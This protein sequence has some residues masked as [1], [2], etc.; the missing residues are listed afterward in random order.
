MS[1]KGG[2]KVSPK[3]IPTRSSA[4]LRYRP[5]SD[6]SGTS[7]LDM[8]LEIRTMIYGYVLATDAD[9]IRPLDRQEAGE[10]RLV[11]QLRSQGRLAR[12]LPMLGHGRN[13]KLML[14]ERGLLSVNK[15][16]HAEATQVLVGSSPVFI[17]NDAMETKNAAMANRV[18]FV[19]HHAKVLAINITSVDM[20]TL[21]MNM[22]VEKTNLKHLR[23]E[24]D[25]DVS[26]IMF[27]W[28]ASKEKTK[29]ELQG[30]GQI[31]VLESMEM[32]YDSGGTFS[33]EF[34][35]EEENIQRFLERKVVPL[36][37]SD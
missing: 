30:L 9:W 23:V 25:D 35:G 16:V 2:K 22:L 21:Y 14:Y 32:V 5:K 13:V 8:S 19:F 7:L 34:D 17:P 3:A 15:Q 36:M 10:M 31:K 1:K 28:I 24:I 26:D 11:A 33:D 27:K 18:A 4:R 29:E 20:D 12:Q 37:L 6:G